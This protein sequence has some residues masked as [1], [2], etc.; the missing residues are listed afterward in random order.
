[1]STYIAPA[2]SVERTD[3]AL[4]NSG[5]GKA[6]Q[7]RV[8]RLNRERARIEDGLDRKYARLS[9]IDEEIGAIFQQVVDARTNEDARKREQRES[10]MPVRKPAPWQPPEPLPTRCAPC[11]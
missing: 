7:A 5:L 3:R 11:P 10:E 2:V 1:M 4:R 9:E 6:D 8:T